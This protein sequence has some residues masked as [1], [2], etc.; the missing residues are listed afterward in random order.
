[1]VIGIFIAL[2]LNNANQNRLDRIAEERVLKSVADEINTYRWQIRRGVRTYDRVVLGSDSLLRFINRKEMDFQVDSIDN[3]L[4]IITDRWLFGKSNINTIYDALT[5]SG[6]LGLIRSDD[7][8]RL[9]NIVKRE[10]L[11][12][13]N[14][15]EIQVNYLDNHLQPIL[16]KYQDGIKVTK[17]R[18]DVF[19]RRY[20]Y[21][22][23]QEMITLERSKFSTDYEMIF[24]DKELSNTLLQHM[25]RSATL[26]PIY[27]RLGNH[28]QLIDSI[29]IDVNPEW[30]FD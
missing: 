8:R 25:R 4:A 2:Q 26:L 22:P 5:G 28:I 1:V 19:T 3:A 16:N 7:L 24:N 30:I 6:E 20:G 17:I 9:L 27:R 21:D 13:G 11:L 23:S 29:L 10:I 12:L 14:Y 15:E 18:E